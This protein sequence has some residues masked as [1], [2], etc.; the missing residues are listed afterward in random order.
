MS[1]DILVAVVGT[2]SI[3]MRHLEVLRRMPGVCPVAVPVRSGR[4]AELR[5]AGYKVAADLPQAVEQGI[6]RCI[7][8][9][10]TGRHL[11]HGLQAI[12]QGMDV[13]IEKPLGVDARQGRQLLARAQEAGR[14]IFVA[15][16]LR[17]SD[18]LNEFRER[19]PKLGRVHAVRIECQ[20]SLS[21]WRPQ[22]SYRESYSARP[23]EGG[24]LRDL[25]HDID[26]AGW[27]YGWPHAVQARLDHSGRLGIQSEE[28]ADLLWTTPDGCR[29]SVRL[30]YLTL[31]ARRRMTA[32]GEGGTA[33][34]DGIVNTVC[35]AL[36]DEAPVRTEY[37]QT[38]E[39]MLEAQAGA[40]LAATGGGETNPRLATAQDGV[41]AL[42]VCDAARLASEHRREE[43][44]AGL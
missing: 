25:I 16:A 42:A 6:T 20:S 35:R 23:E 33:D 22:R 44:V 28:A 9:S 24:V 18:S 43:E 37:A 19:V 11:D 26:Y 2:G 7:V 39:A 29:V 17:F 34:W 8:A 30:D 4:M 5:Q 15:C 40:F 10:D 3:G 14:K 21:Q 1:R 32:F 36:H 38:R 12:E 31:P 13:L 41:R 27:L